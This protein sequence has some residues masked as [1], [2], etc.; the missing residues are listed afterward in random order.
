MGA[1]PDA[2]LYDAIGIGYQRFRR[3]D[4]RI[5]RMLHEPLGHATRVVNVG[6]G[7]GSYEPRERV[8]MAVEPS[9]QMIRQRPVGSAPAVRAVAS[10]LP[11]PDEAFDAAMALL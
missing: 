10:A 2:E 1:S 11:F 3:P 8:V 4:V 5:E 7:A 9:L 6:A